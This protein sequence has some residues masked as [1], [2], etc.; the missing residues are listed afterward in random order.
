MQLYLVSSFIIKEDKSIDSKQKLL[1]NKERILFTLLVS[2]LDKS[3]DFKEE[4]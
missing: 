2:K 3:R 1:E 4:Q